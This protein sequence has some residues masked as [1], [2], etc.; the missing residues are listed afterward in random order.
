MK[1]SASFARTPI[2][3]YTYNSSGFLIGGETHHGADWQDQAEIASDG[4]RHYL[5]MTDY[6]AGQSETTQ[7]NSTMD[8]SLQRLPVTWLS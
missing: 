3:R 6:T 4:L 1:W 5:F 2:R 7:Y 8:R